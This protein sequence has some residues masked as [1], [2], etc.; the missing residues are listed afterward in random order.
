MAKSSA[1]SIQEDIEIEVAE[2]L[3]GMT[4]QAP[5]AAANQQE[6]YK[7]DS[8]DTNGLSTEEKSRVSSPNSTSQGPSASQ[9]SV[10]PSPNLPM[11]ATGG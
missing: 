10:L 1:S 11:V 3:F 6:I 7:V 5:P 4:R 9:P 2:V 8:K